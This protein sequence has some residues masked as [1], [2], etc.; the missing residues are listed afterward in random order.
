MVTRARPGTGP[1]QWT[2]DGKERLLDQHE[3]AYAR[4]VDRLL[5]AGRKAAGCS[6]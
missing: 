6:A 4:A 1:D 3:A 5:L 2:A